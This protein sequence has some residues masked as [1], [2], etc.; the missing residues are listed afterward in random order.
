ML[1]WNSS[2]RINIKEEFEMEPRP[3]I[4][5]RLKEYSDSDFYPFHMPGHKRH[6]PLED[7]N[8]SFNP[9]KIDITEIDGFDNLHHPEGIIRESMEWA[10]KVYGAD[11]TYYLVNGSSCGIL[12]AISGTVEARGNR[13][14]TILISRN[15]HKAVYHGVF[16][17]RFRVKYIYP[18]F[19]HEYG[20]QGGLLP[21]EVEYMLKT[22]SDISAV[23]VVSPTY[24]GVVSDIGAIADICHMHQVPLIVDEAHGAHFRYGNIFP[25]SALD[26]GADIVIQSVHKTLPCFTQSAIMH[27]RKGLVDTKRIEKYLQ[28]YQ[29]SSPSYVLMAGIEQ[30]IQWMETD[31]KRK[32]S[33]FSDHLV[34]LRDSLKNMNHLRLLDDDVIGK[35]GVYDLDPSKIIVSAKRKGISGVQLSEWLRKEFHLEMEMCTADYVTAITTVMDT[36]EGLERLENA[37]MK[38]D[39]W[40]DQNMSGKSGVN[41]SVQNRYPPAESRMTIY[42]AWTALQQSVDLEHSKGQIA[43]EFVYIYPPGIPIIVPGEVITQEIINII[44]EYRDLGLDIQGMKDTSVRRI[45]IVKKKK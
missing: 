30:G 41:L 9:Y 4:Y 31:G 27:V 8:R 29:S 1:E 20:V 12:S 34:K 32:M 17:N 44:S 25:V 43:A 24:D 26:L 15:C 13:E 7:E 10:A 18:Q 36:E 38:I 45:Q 39:Q 35:Y 11:Q 19:I 6:M 2:V 23:L 42:E 14:G 28:I 3:H 22:F 37:L 21:K 5:E 16:L 33:V 40:I